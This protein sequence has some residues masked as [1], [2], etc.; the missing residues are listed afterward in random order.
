MS[1]QK[2]APLRM[3]YNPFIQ[4]PKPQL[5]AEEIINRYSK[6]ELAL[7]FKENGDLKR[8]YQLANRIIQAREKEAILSTGQLVEAIRLKNPA[9]LARVFQAIRIAVN[10]EFK[11]LK[12]ALAE[13]VD[14]LKKGGRL[15]VISYHSGEDRIVKNF[16]RAMEQKGDLKIL[17]KKPIRPTAREIQQNQRARSARLRA[18]QKQV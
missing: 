14:C 13:A 3:L 2:D 4:S 15:A 17:T 12:E 11:N 18:A 16:F 6:K 8:P 9:L 10:D 1:F 7:L 5:T